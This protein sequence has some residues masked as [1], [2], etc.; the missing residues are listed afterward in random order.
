MIFIYHSKKHITIEK[1]LYVNFC[2]LQS[3]WTSRT[4]GKRPV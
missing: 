3:E 4:D 1:R 2:G